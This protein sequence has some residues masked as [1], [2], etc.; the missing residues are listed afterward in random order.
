[1]V[2]NTVTMTESEY[3]IYRYEQLVAARA[4]LD[5]RTTVRWVP[6]AGDDQRCSHR[7]VVERSGR[8]MRCSN[9]A[10]F[11]KERTYD[12]G[13]YGLAGFYCAE[14]APEHGYE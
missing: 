11:V 7:R 13:S 2:R 8:L 5:S 3:E 4:E 10:D 14:H 9:D 1:M 12:D 6:V